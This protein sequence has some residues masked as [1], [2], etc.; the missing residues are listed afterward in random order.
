MTHNNI[1]EAYKIKLRKF[2]D[3][4]E[5]WFPNGKN[6]IRIRLI[7]K[8]QY[9]FTFISDKDWCFETVDSHIKKMKKGVH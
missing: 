8:H 5:A 1:F 7:D 9:V 2:A 3:A 6:S 4:T